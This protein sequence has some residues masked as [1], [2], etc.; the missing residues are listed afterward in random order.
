MK[1]TKQESCKRATRGKRAAREQESKREHER[2][3]S[4]EHE[5][6]VEWRIERG[7]IYMFIAKFPW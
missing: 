1:H 2:E 5:R 6:M 3:R 7:F 4:C